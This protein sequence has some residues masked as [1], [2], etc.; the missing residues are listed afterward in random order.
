M[1]KIVSALLFILLI[2]GCS[3]Q[4][5]DVIN[6]EHREP[7]NYDGKRGMGIFLFAS[8]NEPFW[9]VDLNSGDSTRIYILSENYNVKLNT[10]DPVLDSVAKTITYSFSN[11]AV[12]TLRKAK[13]VDNM[14]GEI[15]EFDALLMMSGKTYNGC[16]KFI[17]ATKNPLIS[18]STLRLNDI[19]ALR[20]FKGKTIIPSDFKEGIPVL[21]LHLNDGR[22]LGNTGCNEVSGRMDVGDS[23]ITLYDFTSTKKHCDGD[24]ESLYLQELKSAD[25][26]TLNKMSLILKKKGEETLVYQKVD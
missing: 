11:G 13:C 7:V 3:S 2:S 22:F 18:Q 10:P 12:L 19:W 23:Y 1:H 6:S 26:W 15:S 9:V 8:G 17:I 21:E 4:K 16:G 20:K 24:F 14:S 25:S 5:P